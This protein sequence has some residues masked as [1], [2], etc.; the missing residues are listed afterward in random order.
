MIRLV[1]VVTS[2]VCVVLLVEL[3]PNL[4]VFRGWQTAALMR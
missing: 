3:N 1:R 2:I 4:L